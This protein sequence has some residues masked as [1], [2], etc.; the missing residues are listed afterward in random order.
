MGKEAIVSVLV[1]AALAVACPRVLFAQ[2][3]PGVIKVSGPADIVSPID[4]AEAILA[5][6]FDCNGTYDEENDIWWLSTSNPFKFKKK[7]TGQW[8]F[9]RLVISD[10][11]DGYVTVKMLLPVFTQHPSRG[12]RS[13]SSEVNLIVTNPQNDEFYELKGVKVGSS[14]EGI[15]RPTYFYIPL[16]Y[17]SDDGRVIIEVLGLGQIGVSQSRLVILKEE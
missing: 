11:T 10:F 15:E 4:N 6:N 12:G 14:R 17:L 5:Y 1:F 9:D 13:A 8:Y 3:E 7:F 2:D 16:K